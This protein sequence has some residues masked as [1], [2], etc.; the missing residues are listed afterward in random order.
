MSRYTQRMYLESGVNYSTSTWLDFYRSLGW[1][2]IPMHRPAERA[3]CDCH[4]GDDCASPAKHPRV[5]W[6]ESDLADPAVQRKWWGRRGQTNI[7][8][9]T[10]PVSGLLVIDIDPDKG[11]WESLR[12]LEA[13]HGEIPIGPEVVTGSHGRHLFMRHPGFYVK[14][15]A[16]VLGP[17]LDVRADRGL[18][19]CPPS[20]HVSGGEYQWLRPPD[21]CSL[22]HVPPWLVERLRP[23]E[24]APRSPVAPDLVRVGHRYVDAVLEGC[25]ADVLSAPTGQHDWTINAVGYRLGR[26]VGAGLLDETLAQRVLDDAAAAVCEKPHDTVTGLQAGIKNP[27]ERSA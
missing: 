27:V 23:Q 11:G 24:R 9:L 5:T 25:V 18:V 19:V 4:R 14:P 3:A 26:F 16:G 22:P 1:Q 8:L 6:S 10:G 13:E 15:T 17:G 21:R 7:G 2:P 12:A 20:L